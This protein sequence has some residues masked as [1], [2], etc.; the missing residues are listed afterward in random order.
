M[1]V[2]RNSLIL[3]VAEG[4]DAMSWEEFVAI[5]QPFLH[6]VVRRTG[7][8]DH[9]ACD[10]VQDVFLMLLRTLPRF[11]YRSERGRFRG[12][13]K[14]IVQNMVVDRLRR[15]GRS[16]EI[17]IGDEAV[18]ELAPRTDD[19]WNRE[20]RLQVARFAQEQVQSSSAEVTWLCF[21]EHVLKR[22]TAAEVAAQLGLSCGA[23]YMNAS[24]T[25]ARIREKCAE[26]D[27]DLINGR[28]AADRRAVVGV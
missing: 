12:W 19:A 6:N 15:K 18:V 16:R 25:L 10:I 11:E 8:N 4:G 22:R 14:T 13:L 2:T 7:M 23:V 17:P 3:R 26:F 24:R 9:D 20:Y 5:Y 27:A 1:P 21:E 28:E